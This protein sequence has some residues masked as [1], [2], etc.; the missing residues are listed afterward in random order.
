MWVFI[1]TEVLLFAGLFV[2]YGV[3][4]YAFTEVFVE[5]H[6]HMSVGLGTVNTLLLVVSSILVALA[7]HWGREGRTLLCSGL[8]WGAVVLG[9][10]FLALKGVEYHHHVREG[11]LPGAWYALEEFA[12]E[13]AALFYSLYWLT[14]GLHALHVT[15]GLGVLGTLAVQ[16]AGGKFSRD[17]HTPLELGGMYW[18]LV[19][20]VWLFVYPLMYLA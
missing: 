18:H 16:A 5:A 15:V 13:G 12:R 17:W 10:A 19:D 3:Y 9:T 8:L 4:R 14:T 11:A 1:A 2:V 7:V 20:V 6:Q